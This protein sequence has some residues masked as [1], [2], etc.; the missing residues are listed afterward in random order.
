MTLVESERSEARNVSG[1]IPEA[2][3]SGIMSTLRMFPKRS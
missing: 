1:I 3:R 2:K